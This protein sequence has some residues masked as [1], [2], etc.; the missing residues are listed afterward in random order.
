MIMIIFGGYIF[1]MSTFLYLEILIIQYKTSSLE[2][3]EFIRFDC[4]ANNNVSGV[5]SS[6]T[7]VK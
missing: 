1:F 5:Q 3:L 7:C 2:N 4:L 6:L